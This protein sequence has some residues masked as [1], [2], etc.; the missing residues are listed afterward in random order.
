[1]SDPG[2]EGFFLAFAGLTPEEGASFEPNIVFPD[3]ANN[4]SLD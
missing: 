1:M 2:E 4:N 3:G